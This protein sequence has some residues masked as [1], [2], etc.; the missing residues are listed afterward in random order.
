MG[1]TDFMGVSDRRSIHDENAHHRQSNEARSIAL[2]TNNTKPGNRNTNNGNKPNRALKR[3]LPR[4]GTRGTSLMKSH[5]RRLQK[6]Y[7]G[8]P[9]GSLMVHD[10]L[11]SWIEGFERY[12]AGSSRGF[13]LRCW[14]GGTFLKD[15]VGK[16]KNDQDAEIRV[17]NLALCV[18][19]GIQPD[20]LT[21]IGDLTSD[22]LLQ[23]ALPCLMRPAEREDAYHP[24]AE[25][26]AQY[27]KLIRSI[28]GAPPETYLFDQDALEVR[29]RIS[30]RLFKLEHFDGFSAALR[31]AI[32]KLKGYFARI[33]LVLE[34]A[35]RHDPAS[36]DG[37]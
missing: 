33:C 3:L 27:D 2:T 23:R 29:D 31:G 30:A 13:F 20:R 34:V 16:G 37:P 18:L 9:R 12:N 36:S 1:K 6:S 28:N 24:V 10:E 7:R 26:N 32:G 35:K 14:N 8:V 11:A 5:R 19:G 25:A 4:H 15:R 21:Q 17:E 22:G